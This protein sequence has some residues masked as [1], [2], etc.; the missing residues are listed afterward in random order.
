MH[1]VVAGILQLKTIVQNWHEKQWVHFFEECHIFI[2]S[3]FIMLNILSASKT[4]S[5]C[6][7]CYCYCRLLPEL[8]VK[9]APPFNKMVLL[10]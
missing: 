1:S 4:V 6:H 8:L 5:C 10:T 9:A 2:F 7:I 3:C